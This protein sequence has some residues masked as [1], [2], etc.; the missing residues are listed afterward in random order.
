MKERRG[1]GD[2]KDEM[3]EIGIHFLPLLPNR[4]QMCAN[5][6]KSEQKM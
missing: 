6:T 1:E 2:A 4:Q 5:K 3:R